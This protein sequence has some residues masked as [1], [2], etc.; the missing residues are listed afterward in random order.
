M[1][2]TPDRQL[3]IEEI[4]KAWATFLERADRAEQYQFA[5]IAYIQRRLEPLFN[6]LHKNWDNHHANVFLKG[7]DAAYRTLG[8]AADN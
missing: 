2:N 3:T 1:D 5:R 8:W 6:D 7:I 4:D